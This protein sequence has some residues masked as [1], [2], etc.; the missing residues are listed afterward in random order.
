MLAACNPVQVALFVT[1][2]TALW[3]IASTTAL[4]TVPNAGWLFLTIGWG[5]AEQFQ[6]TIPTGEPSAPTGD[7][8]RERHARFTAPFKGC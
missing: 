6:T 7:E 5:L 8:G 1:L 4:L 3:P 2:C